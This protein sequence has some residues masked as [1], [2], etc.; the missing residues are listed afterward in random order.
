MA[1]GMTMESVDILLLKVADCKD[2]LHWRWVLTDNAD[3]ILADQEVRLEADDPNYNEMIDL[4]SYLNS[5][6]SPDNRIVD[7]LQLLDEIGTWIGSNIL[8]K[9]GDRLSQYHTPLTIRV[10]IPPDAPRLA[11]LPLEAARIGD[12]P[13]ALRDISLIFELEGRKIDICPISKKLRILAI[14]SLPTD[15]SAL[16]LRRERYELMMLISRIAQDNN[17]AIE[18]RVLQYGAT[19]GNIKDALKEPEGWDI[20]HLSGH[21]ERATMILENPDGSMDPI[22]SEDLASLLSLARGRLKLVTLS[23][24]L[25]AAATLEETMKWLKIQPPEQLQE[26]DASHKPDAIVT[27]SLARQLVEDLD[28]AVL[29]MRYPVGDEFAIKLSEDLYKHLLGDNLTLPRSLQLSMKYALEQG[30]NAASPPLSLA[31]PALFGRLATDLIISSPK[32]AGPEPEQPLPGMANFPPEPRHFVGR[33]G[34]LIRASSA[35]AP[36]WDKRGV[37]FHGMAGGGKTACAR[38]LAYHHSRT[39][40]FDGFVWHEVPEQDIDRSL[41][42]LATSMEAQLPGFKMA[43]AMGD[44]D[45]FKKFL[46]ML[47]QLLEQNSILVILDHLEPLLNDQ[48]NWRDDRWGLLIEALLNHNGKSRVIL[49]SRQIPKDL[50]VERL[51]VEPIRTL[52][53]KE[54][55]LLSREMPNLGNLLVGK[56][57]VGLEKGRELVIRVLSLVK[58]HPMLIEMAES[59]ASDPIKLEGYLVSSAESWKDESGLLNF[60]QDG[61][62]S[63]NA[64]KL[65]DILKAWTHEISEN[66]PMPTRT[67]FHFLCALEETDRM[68]WI[69]DQVWP[70]LWTQMKL[71]DLAPDIDESLADLKALVEVQSQ[72]DTFRYII[73]PAVAEA[74]LAGAKE[75]FRSLVDLEIASFWLSMVDNAND[76]EIKNM[77]GMIAEACLRSAP[78]LMRLGEWTD[79]AAYLERA[80]QMDKSPGVISTVL[81]TIKRIADATVGTGT[82]NGH[83]IAVIFARALI[84][85]GRDNEAEKNLRSLLVECVD[86][87]DFKLALGIAAEIFGILYSTGRYEEALSL[88]EVMEDYT[89]KA[90]LGLWTQLS[91]K[92]LTLKVQNKKGRYKDVLEVAKMLWE[93]IEA[94]PLPDNYQQ[95]DSVDPW[96]V[97]KEILSVGTFAARDYGDYEQAL[98]F[99][100]KARKINADRGATE[101]EPAKNALN[102]YF[103]LLMLN[104]YSQA[105]ELLLG[106]KKVFEREEDIESLGLV[107]GALADLM[108]RQGRTSQAVKFTEDALR[109]MY[110]MGNIENIPR[111]HNNL[112]TYLEKAGSSNAVSQDIAAAII[113]SLISSGDLNSA[114]ENLSFHLTGFGPQAQPAT[115]DQLCQTVEAV[116]GV[117]FSELFHS[118]AGLDANGDQIMQEVIKMA[119]GGNL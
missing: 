90:G 88:T 17:L 59:Q 15:V 53:L 13:L 54:S 74:G 100:A 8:G 56:S 94:N 41:L 118:L 71:S 114:L 117:K 3:N 106:C 25:S 83:A 6:S 75:G 27:S 119:K 91:N 103:P 93:H 84:F 29:A 50:Q 109:Y 99:N 45:A 34:P 36:D 87:S 70:H 61:E 63:Q 11:Y 111:G 97:K 21:G 110:R 16:A 32:V 107:F 5:Y 37:L 39:P 76:I 92:V 30:Y 73:H 12:Q 10:L 67:L 20:I 115:F 68:G 23:S 51:I 19:W 62:S 28:C 102:D 47:K 116:K 104:R 98:E 113:R 79:A 35:L 52:S 64:E 72:G 78:Y 57:S 22:T 2:Y 55:L 48:G 38:E 31:T 82:P 86:K 69:A 1:Y 44:T 85:A 105:E 43:Y 65:I 24:C 42:D 46:P 33:A 26:T 80:M 95:E 49:T 66:I 77:A 60:F 4:Y 81:P 40:R 7:Q 89:Q 112:A 18:L 58:G 14:F 96:D 108:D 101:L 9:V